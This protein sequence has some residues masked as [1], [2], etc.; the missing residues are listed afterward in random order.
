MQ[1]SWT[2]FFIEIINFIILVWILKHL[3][4]LPI[5]NAIKK[6]QQSIEETLNKTNK[7]KEEAGALKIKYENRLKDW[8]KEK[9]QQKKKLHQEMTELEQ[10]ELAKLHEVLVKE[11][12]KA[13]TITQYHFKKQMEIAV[14][15]SMI[16]AT[17]FSAK[18]LKRF[19]DAELQKKVLEVFVENLSVI[20]QEQLQS[21]KSELGNNS[22]IKIQSAFPL[23][24]EQKDII[25]GNFL[26]IFAKKM[27]F[28]FS[29]QPDL[30]AGISVQI[31]SM[32]LQ[33]NLRDE[34]KFFTEVA[35]ESVQI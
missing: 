27:D 14:Q 13:E 7:L 28:N 19:A 4:Y 22:I 32:T 20:P 11:K 23:N 24:N 3:L 16:L 18:F 6:R 34:L 26:K 15:E 31:G 21:L 29:Q 10:K 25:T 8:E 30:L 2:T 1:F 35:R 17:S 9:E 5:Q 33:A 12:E